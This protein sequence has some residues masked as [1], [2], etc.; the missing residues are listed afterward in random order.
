MQ[1]EVAHWTGVD[2]VK[3]KAKFTGLREAIQKDLEE[4]FQ[5]LPAQRPAAERFTRREAAKRAAAGGDGV[6]ADGEAP[7]GAAAGGA[8]PAAAEEPEVVRSGMTGSLMAP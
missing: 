2:L 7:P 5:R 6:A 3:V 8:A 4:A 1:A